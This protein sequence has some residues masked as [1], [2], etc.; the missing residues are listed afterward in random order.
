MWHKICKG[1]LFAIFP[2]IRK[3]KLPQIKFTAN[4]F[5]EKFT[6]EQIFSKVNSLQ[7][8]TVVRNC[9][10]LTT[11]CSLHPETKWVQWITDFTYAYCSIVWKY[12][13]PLHVRKKNENNINVGYRVLD[14][15]WK[16]QKL[17]PSKK[18]SV[19]IAKICSHTVF[20]NFPIN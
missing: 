17:I 15:F 18:Q 6:P 11:T 9:V 3:N 14:T 20:W 1:S 8:N 7:K 13:F 12:I 10:C 16:S 5:S 2:A 19:L 4:I